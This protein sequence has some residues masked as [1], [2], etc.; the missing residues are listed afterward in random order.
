MPILRKTHMDNPS[1]CYLSQ[2]LTYIYG[3]TKTPLDNAH[4]S[5]QKHSFYTG[6]LQLSMRNNSHCNKHMPTPNATYPQGHNAISKI[7]M[8]YTDS[9]AI[10]SPHARDAHG[11]GNVSRS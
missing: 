10:A 11:Q 4:T 8:M 6:F 1:D 2:K 7:C 5:H 9:L 3:N